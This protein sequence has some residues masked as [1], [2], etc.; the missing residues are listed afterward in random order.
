MVTVCELR[1][2]CSGQEAGMDNVLHILAVYT[3]NRYK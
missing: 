3:T 1:A 2:V